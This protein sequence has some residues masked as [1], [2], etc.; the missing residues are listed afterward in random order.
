MRFVIYITMLIGSLPL[1]FRFPFFGLCV[2]LTVSFAEP[3]KLCWRPDTQDSLMI[4]ACFVAGALLFGTRRR[5]VIAETDDDTGALKSIRQVLRRSA[6][7]EPSLLLVP[8]LL[9][10]AY[11]G[12][13]RLLGEAGTQR[14]AD[15]YNRLCKTTLVT[16]LMTGLVPD[17][18]RTRI[19]YGV[20]ALAAGFWAIRGGLKV[21]MIGPHQV[22]GAD[23][24]NNLFALKSVMALPLL[25]YLGVTAARPRWRWLLYA[26]TALVVLAVLG[27][28]S[29]SGF[30]ALVS[31]LACLAWTSG[32]RLRA[33]AGVTVVAAV[34][35]ALSWSD[36][37]ARFDSIRNYRTDKSA[38]GRLRIWPL[39]WAM[40]AEKPVTGV[41]FNQ[42]E[43]AVKKA[44]GNTLAAHNIWIQNLVELGMVGHPLWLATVV[45]P[46]IGLSTL[47][48]RARR[49]PPALRSYYFLARGLLLSYVGFWIHGMF[50]N[51]EYLDL[52]Y[53]CLGL[54]VSLR[55]V[56][57]RHWREMRLAPLLDSPPIAR[58]PARSIWS[59]P[60]T[61]WPR[62]AVANW[63]VR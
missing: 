15:E 27:S 46:M 38:Q 9:L 12:L 5:D 40:L 56:Y 51:E 52:M 45:G 16:L 47:M 50:H 30:L 43:N 13:S 22:Y 32:R 14:A 63:A 35:V 11:I 42:F 23:Y 6:L 58:P 41:G 54:T 28:K 29:R 24:D 55:V 34:A 49:G 44:G 25:Y 26:C 20:I 37:S 18:R 59:K 33:M 3:K 21:L 17:L 4:G 60:A 53:A 39:A 2:Y 61:A 19:V 8:P 62:P 57:A 1:A 36:I 7:V 10:I 31:V 48:W